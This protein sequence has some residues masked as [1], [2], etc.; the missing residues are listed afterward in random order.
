MTSR[1]DVLVAG[2]GLAGLSFAIQLKRRIPALDIAVIDRR[3]DPLPA[4][5]HK[6]GEATAELSAYYY[7]EIVGAREHLVTKQIIKSGLRIYMSDGANDD[8][9]TRAE[10][11][12]DRPAPMQAYNLHR[13]SF[14]QELRRIAR[15]LGVLLLT[16]ANVSAIELGPELHEIEVQHEG[17]RRTLKARWLVDASGRRALMRK[18]LGLTQSLD[19]DVSASWFRVEAVIDIDTWGDGAWRD[20]VARDVRWRATNHLVGPG[21]W[22]WLIPLGHVATSI[23]IVAEG[24]LHPFSG[25]SDLPSAL[26]WIARREP[27]L[28]KHMAPH[29]STISGFGAL[30]HYAYGC[31]R[32]Y[33]PD[34]WFLT[35]EA[36]LFADPLLSPGSDF[37][38]IGN[39]MI[40]EI[41][42]AELCGTRAYAVREH[43]NVAFLKLFD[44]VF[45]FFR[46]QYPLFGHPQALVLKF[47]FDFL[48]YSGFVL[49]AFRYGIFQRYEQIARIRPLL[50]RVEA[51]TVQMEKL[52]RD[53]A[54][55]HTRELRACTADWAQSPLVVRMQRAAMVE[56][57]DDAACALIEEHV[58]IV[59]EAA[60]ALFLAAIE[61]LGN[62]PHTAA[63]P[64][65]LVLDAAQWDALCTFDPAHAI[66]PRE[67]V[68][69]AL[70][71]FWFEHIPTAFVRTARPAAG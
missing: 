46:G 38:A 47:M 9:T 54:Q 16:G 42:A 52:F 66:T 41:I 37:I 40:C 22:V 32:V 39:T 69:A 43:C 20:R 56:R 55:S 5:E 64:A 67:E 61:R 19:H 70:R 71:P 59:E 45:K 27:Q 62:G 49:T 4:G 13:S 11:A 17:A 36:A 44:L 29:E 25:F 34:R 33:S 24:S 60:V 12:A 65:G 21:Y 31:Q 2:G 30:R 57:T 48:V 50:L 7:R 1:V 28:A 10:L 58:A 3:E 15:E 18:R 6:V 26:T 53:L 68:V 8:I 35:G 51:L 14:E 63:N 23:G